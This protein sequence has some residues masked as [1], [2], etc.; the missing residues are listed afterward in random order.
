MGC[1]ETKRRYNKLLNTEDLLKY[2][3]DEAQEIKKLIETLKG[4][5]IIIKINRKQIHKRF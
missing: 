5:Y 4:K 1:C 2:I 3:N